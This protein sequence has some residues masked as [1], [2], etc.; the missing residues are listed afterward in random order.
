MIMIVK[1]LILDRG[2]PLL[3]MYFSFV[4]LVLQTSSTDLLVSSVF[5]IKCR[6]YGLLC[7][8][9]GRISKIYK[10]LLGRLL[11]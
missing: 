9:Q 3:E 5:A 4:L 8:V 7:L 6:E 10:V 2:A 1:I 11:V